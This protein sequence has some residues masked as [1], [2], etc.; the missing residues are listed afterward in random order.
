MARRS[1]SPVDCSAADGLTSLLAAT[2]Y[3]DP[4]TFTQ[5]SA[6]TGYEQPLPHDVWGENTLESATTEV[7]PLLPLL[8]NL[9]HAATSIGSLDSPTGPRSAQQGSHASDLANPAKR[10]RGRPRKTDCSTGQYPVDRRREQVRRAQEAFRSRQAANLANNEARIRQLETAIWEMNSIVTSL[11]ED[12]VQ[13]RLLLSSPSLETRLCSTLEKSQK[14]YERNIPATNEDR[15]GTSTTRVS[16][17]SL[18]VRQTMQG[19]R[20]ETCSSSSSAPLYAAQPPTSPHY[21]TNI[22]FSG[23]PM[24]L[25]PGS[26]L[27]FDNTDMS[28]VEIPLFI[29]QLSRAC[30]YHAYFSLRNPF[31]QLDDLRNKFRFL[32]SMLSRESLTSYY[33]AVVQVDVYPTRMEEWKGVPFLS[34]GGAGTHYPT[35]S[36]MLDNS[37][38][39]TTTRTQP[40]MPSQGKKKPIWFDIQDLQGFL[41]ERNAYLLT[42]A[43]AEVQRHPSRRTAIN[44][45]RLI[46]TLIGTCVCLGSSPG[47]R[48]VDV[49]QALHAALWGTEHDVQ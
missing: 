32:L 12:L 39:G 3:L 22:D 26:P 31:V 18:R 13:S 40:Q 36:P 42:N 33:E 2:S 24:P 15:P 43:H 23:L 37:L 4:Q 41:Q 30:A 25:S 7:N 46:R 48:Q 9:E 49:E 27:L 16:A 38:G 5:Q 21:H 47:W 45:S 29:R 44:P 28:L 17:T 11:G 14:I 34:I 8:R 6:Q 35:P 19:K 1:F 10:K 20:G